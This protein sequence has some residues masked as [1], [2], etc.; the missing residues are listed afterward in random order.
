MA[1]M[2]T[3]MLLLIDKHSVT[4][5]WFMLRILETLRVVS[6]MYYTMYSLVGCT[7]CMY[8]IQV[9]EKFFELKKGHIGIVE[10]AQETSSDSAIY[11]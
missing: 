7:P 6:S 10:K 11:A 4:L 8:I 3:C 2:Q 9:N 5:K 1:C